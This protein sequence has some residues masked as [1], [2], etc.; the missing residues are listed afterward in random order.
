MHK[1]NDSTKWIV[2]R[3]AGCSITSFSL[4]QGFLFC[5][6]AL[7]FCQFAGLLNKSDLTNSAPKKEAFQDL[8]A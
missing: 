2:G 5:K 6:Q 8:K 4:I 7:D 3:I 1:C